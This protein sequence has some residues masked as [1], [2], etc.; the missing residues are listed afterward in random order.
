MP[1]SFDV[2][3]TEITE[4]LVPGSAVLYYR[5]GGGIYQTAPLTPLGGDLYSATL[6]PANCG[7]TPEF[8]VRADGDGGTSVFSPANAPIDIYSAIVGQI[9]IIID[10]NFETDMGWTTENLGASSGDWER[11]R[12]RLMTM[13]GSMTPHPIP[14]AADS[15]T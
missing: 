1:T 9:V 11:G 14:T 8:Y 10:D 13:A 3:I 6:P 15:A 12:C 5:Y 4:N 2:E 7:D